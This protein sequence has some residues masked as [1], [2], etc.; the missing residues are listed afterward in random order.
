MITLKFSMKKY[1][2]IK[3][4]HRLATTTQDL[5][6]LMYKFGK[7][8]QI[9]DVV[10]VHLGDDQLQK[11]ETDTCGIFRLYFNVNLFTLLK[12]SSIVNHKKLLK[13]TLEKLLNEIFYLDRDKNESLVEQ[14]AVEKYIAKGS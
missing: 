4:C 10:T 7:L 11:T 9:N 14:F 12:N 3:N 1:E 8:H 5:L 13:S 2:K 6:H